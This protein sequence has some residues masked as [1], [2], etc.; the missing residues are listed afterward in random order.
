LVV[1][2]NSTDETARQ[3]IER[4][5]GERDVPYLA[6][7]PSPYTHIR[8]ASRSHGLALNWTYENI[9][10]PAKPDLFGFLDHDIIPTKTIEPQRLLANQ[11]IFGRVVVRGERWYLWP[12]YCF[13]RS[14]AIPAGR[15]DFRQDW[16]AGL[17]TGGMNWSVFYKNLDREKLDYPHVR[18]ETLGTA[19]TAEDEF[20]WIDD[21]LHIANAS[22][23]RQVHQGRRDHIEKL[24]SHLWERCAKHAGNLKK[25]PVTPGRLNV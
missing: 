12:G 3:E 19:S 23:W 21:V 2:D 8:Y 18:N 7:P 16:F 11:P 5:C 6:L 14:D 10:R 20:E 9:V 15:L 22:V 17:D 24:L 1:A 4:I 13:F 25:E